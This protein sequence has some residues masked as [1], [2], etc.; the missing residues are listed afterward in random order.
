M[1]NA[2]TK[3]YRAQYYVNVH[4]PRIDR[5]PELRERRRAAF[6]RWRNNHPEKHA[7][8]CRAWSKKHP[9][10]VRIFNLRGSYIRKLCLEHIRKNFPESYK[11]PWNRTTE[12]Y[13][14]VID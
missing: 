6:R 2:K 1:N 9:Q 5:D 11:I 8:N 4:K 3:E 12:K 7:A 14:M 13:P 10:I